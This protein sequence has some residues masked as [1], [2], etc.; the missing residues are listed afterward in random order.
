MG[1]S[2]ARYG[3]TV[4]PWGNQFECSKGNFDDEAIISDY[5][6]PGGVDCDGYNVTAPGGS[7]LAGA[8]PYGALDMAGNVWEW[9][10][11]WYDGRY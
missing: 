3:S 2:G 11:D 5:V 1:K 10:A 7:F 6:V 8:S 9:V 4:L